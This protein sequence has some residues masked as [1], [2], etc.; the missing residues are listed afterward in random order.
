MAVIDIQVQ[1][2]LNSATLVNINI[3]DGQTVA[4]LRTAVGAADGVDPAIMQL[5]LNSVLLQD[6][7]TLLASGVV[8]GSVLSASNNIAGLATREA[9][10]IA[11]LDLA[12]A[13]RQANGDNTQPYFRVLNVYDRD[14][15]PAKYV[16]NNSVPNV[17]PAG[18]VQGRPWEPQP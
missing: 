18:L 7:D 2:L 13:R 9:R 12:E 1:S 3:D 4:D 16:G 5:F 10:Q 15:L 6:A 8:D 11:K 14:L 17:H